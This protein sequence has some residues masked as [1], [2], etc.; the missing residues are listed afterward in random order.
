MRN[1]EE[2]TTE[3]GRLNSVV[4]SLS[5]ENSEIKK[6][7]KSLEQKLIELDALN[8][9][10]EE[11]FKLMQKRKYGQSSEKTDKDQLS[12]FDDMLNEAES[13]SNPDKEEPDT[14]Q[15]TYKRK[16]RTK[17]STI[18]NLPVEEIH[19]ELSSEECICEGLFQIPCKL[20]NGCNL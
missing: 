2:M 3:I 10:Y 18:E 4:S 1:T 5:K 19:H 8:K 7:K 9:Y 11:Q 15:I 12:M 6:E 13:Q 16:K 20:R 14:E 17:E